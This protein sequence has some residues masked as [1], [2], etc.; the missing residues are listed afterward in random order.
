MWLSLS[1]SF[2]EVVTRLSPLCCENMAQSGAILKI[3]LLI[4]SCN[5]SVPCMEVVSYAVQVLLHVAKVVFRFSEQILTQE[6]R[7]ASEVS[8]CSSPECRCPGTFTH[9]HVLG[10]QGLVCGRRCS[11][12][13]H[14]L[15]TGPEAVGAVTPVLERGGAF[16]SSP[17]GSRGSAGAELDRFCLPRGPGPQQVIRTPCSRH[18]H[19]SLPWRQGP[20]CGG[21][22]SVLS[23][24]AVD[25]M[26]GQLFPSPTPSPATAEGSVPRGF[27]WSGRGPD[28]SSGA[29]QEEQVRLGE[30]LR[31]TRGSQVTHQPFAPAAGGPGA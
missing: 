23:R 31:T 3:F 12:N 10:E 15:S 11:R 19:C 29:G 5:R 8:V 16:Q 13:W 25:G 2:P 4:R 20:G 7:S 30:G 9:L 1:S 22:R 18:L 6:V 14:S 21:R 17:E 24:W 27:P 28:T 26:R